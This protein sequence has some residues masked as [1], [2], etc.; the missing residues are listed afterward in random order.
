M[1]T[2]N[3]AWASTRVPLEEHKVTE[4]EYIGQPEYAPGKSDILHWARLITIGIEFMAT[5]DSFHL[6]YSDDE[7][8][9]D[10]YW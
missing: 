5:R 4:T 3:V 10:W 8:D 9:Y 1:A 2:S 7:L 6:E